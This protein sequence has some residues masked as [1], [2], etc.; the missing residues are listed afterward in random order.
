MTTLVGIIRDALLALMVRGREYKIAE[1]EDLARTVITLDEDDWVVREYTYDNE[2]VYAAPQ[3]VFRRQV[4][5]T[6]RLYRRDDENIE[7][8]GKDKAATRYRI[9]IGSDYGVNQDGATDEN[10]AELIG[11][12]PPANAI[13]SNDGYD[14]ERYVLKKFFDRGLGGGNVRNQNQGFDLLLWEGDTTNLENYRY[15]EV[16]SCSTGL[17]RPQLTENEW[18]A[19]ERFGE[20][21]ILAC[22]DNWDGE[23]GDIVFYPNPTALGSVVLQRRYYRISRP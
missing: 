11:D 10:L 16:K 19:A 21:Y 15:V 17:V 20:R 18:R 13:F 4:L 14:A 3:L 6:L 8:N 1:L 22:V 9:L 5:N 2:N 23:G 12:G 7:W